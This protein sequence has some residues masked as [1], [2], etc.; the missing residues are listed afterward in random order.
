VLTCGVGTA[1][2]LHP[3]LCDVL[4]GLGMQWSADTGVVVLPCSTD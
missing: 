1:C 3:A 2:G 4:T